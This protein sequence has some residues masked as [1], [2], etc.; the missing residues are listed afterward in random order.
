MRRAVLSLLAIGFLAPGA[1]AETVG[2]AILVVPR[3]QAFLLSGEASSD[4]K[5]RDLVERGERVKLTGDTSRLDVAFSQAFACGAKISKTGP[6][7]ISVT[8]VLKAKGL[9]DIEL[10]DAKPPCEPKLRI[11]LGKVWLAMLRSVG[12]ETPDADVS[13]TGTYLR[14][15]VDPLVGTFVAVD[16]GVVIVQAKA[17][18][19]PVSVEAGHWVVVPPGGLATQ[20]Q[21][22]GTGSHHAAWRDLEDPPLL[23][24]LDISTEPP[25][26]K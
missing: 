2:T 14:L 7:V 10:G 16:E 9:S 11:T 19:A 3:V 1:S 20:A 12:I 13:V 15:L 21:S 23:D 5:T 17:G 6:Q 4:M 25:K 22:G 24:G 18:G 26:R 8:G